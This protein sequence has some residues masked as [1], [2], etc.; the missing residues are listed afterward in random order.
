MALQNLLNQTV[1]IASQS[2]FDAYGREVVGTAASYQ[3]RI[4]EVNKSRLL[5]NG[6]TIVIDAIAYL[7]GAAAVNVN[8]RV[9][10]GS[11]QYKVHGKSTGIDG[12]GNTHHTKVELVKWV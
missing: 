8:D 2:S 6:Q 1:S 3:A 11:T 10:Y 7:D 12:Q 9:T 4:Q 5:P